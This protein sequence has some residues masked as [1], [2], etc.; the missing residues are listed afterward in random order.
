MHQI[1]DGVDPGQGGQQGDGLEAV[2]EA[3]L[4]PLRQPAGAA[5]PGDDPIA[6]RLQVGHQ[7]RSDITGRPHHQTCA[8]LFFSHD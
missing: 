6:Q 8:H 1:E 4:D 2:G 7:I 5:G 3:K